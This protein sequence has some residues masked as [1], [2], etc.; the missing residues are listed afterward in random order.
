[1]DVV[2]ERCCGLD[3]HQRTVVACVVVPGPDGAPRKTIRTFGTMTEDLLTLA[4]WLA[5]QGVSQVAMES[6][7][8]YVRRFTAR[9]IPPAGRTGSEGYR[10]AND[11]PGGESP[12]GQEHVVEA[13]RDR[14]RGGLGLA[15]PVCDG[16]SVVA[17]TPFGARP[18][19]RAI[20]SRFQCCFFAVPCSSSTSV[21]AS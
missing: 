14:R 12:R 4:D 19:S 15:R 21:A 11:S 6:T 20:S 5:E 9:A 13:G 16:A 3:L 1:M 7:G 8:V 17:C 2:D 10:W 18:S